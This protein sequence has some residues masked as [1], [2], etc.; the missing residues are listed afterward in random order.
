MT[1]KSIL[2]ATDFSPQEH[3]ALRRA[4]RLAD[5]HRASVTLMYLPPAGRPVPAHAA[6]RLADAARQLQEVLELRVRTVPLLAHTLQD[7]VAQSVGRDLVVLPHRRDRSAAAWLHGQ[8]VL[9][10]LRACTCPVLVVRQPGDAH[11][12][13]IL[14]PVDF[15]P[16]SQGLAR[17][18][19]RFD[20][21]AELEIFHA[22]SSVE[23]IRL[24]SA[25]AG[26]QAVGTFRESR[27]QQA[28]T[29]L[30]AMARVLATADRQVRTALGRGDAGVESVIRQDHAG[31][32]LVVVGKRPASAWEDFLRGSVAQRVLRRGRGDVLLVP[33][34]GQDDAVLAA[35]G[36]GH[37]EVRATVALQAAA[38]RLS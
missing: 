15:S 27:R 6:A 28:R 14:V 38:R 8:P 17:L 24:R 16:A 5:A 2:V 12:R 25:G 1:I 30:L 26:E 36:R 3:A 18:A 21:R 29:R 20:P 33:L 22:I 11:Y 23:E 4:W 7:V 10:V 19:A 31:A 13:R 9:R 35:E 32:D 34:R 37:G